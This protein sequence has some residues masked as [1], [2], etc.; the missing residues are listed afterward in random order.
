MS[1]AVPP[2]VCRTRILGRSV[3]TVPLRGARGLLSRLQE[4]YRVRIVGYKDG[5]VIPSLKRQRRLTADFADASGS[6][7]RCVLSGFLLTT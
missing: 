1:A 4:L 6:D 5:M 3:K 7:A 2:G